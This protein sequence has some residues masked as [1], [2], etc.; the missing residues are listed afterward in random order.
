MPDLLTKLGSKNNTSTEGTGN[1][2][3]RQKQSQSN[4]ELGGLKGTSI[5]KDMLNSVNSKSESAAT[6]QANT[7]DVKKESNSSPKVEPKDEE[8]VSEPSTWTKESALKEV[9]KLRE[10]NKAYR[11]KYEESVEELKKRTEE[12]MQ[13]FKA[14]IDEAKRAKDELEEIKTKEADRKRSLEEKLLHRESLLADM[15]VRLDQIEQTSKQ[16]ETEMLSQVEAYKAER[17]AEEAAYKRRLETELAT[18]PEKF[19][20]VADLIVKGAGDARDAL[21]A[22]GEAKIQGVF[23]DKT[24]LVN[25]SVPGA[26]DGARATKDSLDEASKAARAKMT[27][28]QK[29]QEALKQIRQGESNSAF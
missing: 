1:P 29:I 7:A 19:K 11:Q 4:D 2:E 14:E 18:V 20:T 15:K 24:I 13:S 27:S 21:V 3:P 22:L 6:G 16:K 8:T 5:G 25:H 26:K 9:K 28:S 12:R 23:D 17:A 10:E